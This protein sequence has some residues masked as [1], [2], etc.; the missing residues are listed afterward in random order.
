MTDHKP[1]RP[2][3][4][5]WELVKEGVDLGGPPNVCGP[6][7]MWIHRGKGLQVFSSVDQNQ[8]GHEYVWHVSV[9]DATGATPSRPSP[10]AVAQTAL[11]F[12][13]EL[14][15]GW[16]QQIEGGRAM[17]LFQPITTIH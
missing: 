11:A 1:K 8:R 7:D 12:D 10:L 13:L 5:G 16:A 3:N 2:T 6:A 4:E 17:N 9:V 15:L 14:S